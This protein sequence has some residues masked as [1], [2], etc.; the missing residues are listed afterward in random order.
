MPL[1]MQSAPIRRAA[2]TVFIK[3]WATSVS[4]FGTPAMSM[5]AI[6][7]RELTIWL[8]K[9]S[10]TVWVRTVSSADQR[11]SEDFV[12]ELHHRIRKLEQ[13]LRLALDDVVAAFVRPGQAEI[14]LASATL[15]CKATE[16]CCRQ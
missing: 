1:M 13:L 4:T 16:E 11:Q 3:F 9:F 10:I 5:M 7:A 2:D 6:S 8:S 14:P 15:A 12:P